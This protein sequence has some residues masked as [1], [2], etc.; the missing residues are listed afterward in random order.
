LDG[1]ARVWEGEEIKW[2]SI[3]IYPKNFIKKDKIS[4][5]SVLERIWTRKSQRE[6]R[7][8]SLN[9]VALRGK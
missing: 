1:H 4:D 2:K 8:F 3:K 6:A 5:E 9:K 7:N